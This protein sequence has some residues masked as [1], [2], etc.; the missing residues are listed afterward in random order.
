MLGVIVDGII[1]IEDKQP[2]L[3]FIQS[4]SK[5]GGNSK[6]RVRK[7]F[8]K[9]E[10]QVLFEFINRVLLSY[11]EK[12]TVTFASDLFLMEALSMFESINL[13]ALIIK[14]LYKVMNIKDGNHGLRYGYLFTKLFKYFKVE[15]VR[16]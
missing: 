5:V 7:K 16:E 11:S 9:E 12:R 10:F 8:L 6:A 15:Y 13:L 2:S 3:P 1:S 4:F 14:H